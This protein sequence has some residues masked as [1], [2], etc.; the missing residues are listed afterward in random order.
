[1]TFQELIMSL[2]KFWAKQGCL[3]G[4]PYDLEVGAGTFNP[5][6]FLRCLGPDPWKTA[7]VEPARRPTDGRYA[8][9]PLR[10]QH[11]YQYQVILKPSPDNIQDLYIKSLQS[12]GIDLKAHDLRFVEDDWESPTLGAWGLGWEVWLDSLEITQFTYFQQVGGIDLSPISVELTYGLERICM[13]LQ[14]EYDLFNLKWNDDFTYG[15]MHRED[16]IQWS[17]Y[18]F[19][20]ADIELHTRLFNDYEQQARNLLDK[21][22]LLPAYDFVLKMSHTFNM[23]DARGAVSVTERPNYVA[24]VRAVSKKCAQMYVGE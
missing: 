12:L 19:E 20:H 22:L 6:T 7:Y 21:E 13:F 1:M 14:E 9:N 5:L 23:L 10:T 4:Q 3:L 16:E 8:Q 24:R 11:Y 18:N 17:K 2:Q 15:Q